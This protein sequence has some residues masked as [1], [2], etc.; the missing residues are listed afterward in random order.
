[1]TDLLTQDFAEHW[2]LDPVAGLAGV[3]DVSVVAGQ[4]V[5]VTWR[6]GEAAARTLL[7]EGIG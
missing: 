1:M 5:S 6:D 3:A 2:V 7:P 4:I